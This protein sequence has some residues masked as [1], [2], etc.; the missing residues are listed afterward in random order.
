[1]PTRRA[2]LAA[3]PAPALAQPAIGEW[4]SRPLRIILPTPPGGAFDSTA[5]LIQEPL[6][7][8]LGQPVVVENRAGGAGVPAMQA[9]LQ[10]ADGHTVGLIGSS[11][12]AN[13]SLMPSL[14]F[15]PVTDIRPVS[16]LARWPNIIACHPAQPWRNL[17]ELVAAAR[18]QPGGIAY[19]SPG[20]GLS[21]HLAGELLRI[22]AQADIQHV[23]YRGAGPA[24]ADAVAGHVP[25]VISAVAS[26]AAPVRAGRLRALAS[27][28]LVRSPALPEVPT[29]AEQGFAG[30]D[31][32]EWI[33]IV[34][35]RQMPEAHA[36]RLGQALAA[37]M[38]DREV[39]R[40]L[41]DSG[42][43][44]LSQDGRAFG[45]FLGQQVAVLGQII[46]TANIRPE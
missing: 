15:D 34:G 14:P 9:V 18:A 44:A 25:L 19:A 46:R 20:I 33:G 35:P 41:L 27:T 1:M 11:H 7:R 45:A 17:G 26:A 37:S 10:A 21:Q 38:A 22:R 2:L 6:A 12:A 13:V 5:R 8:L 30:F 36:A 39:V 40:R 29:V 16:L 24:L 43:E 3:I 42:I 31:V 32:G 28:G 23:P 4:P